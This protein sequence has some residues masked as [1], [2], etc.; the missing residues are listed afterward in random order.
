MKAIEKIEALTFKRVHSAVE[1]LRPGIALETVYR[2]RA[3]LRAG[4]GVPDPV[5]AVLIE[6]TR[7]TE[8]PIVF[9]DFAPPDM[10]ARA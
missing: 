6:A 10:G 1:G 9:A 5:K 8:H 2:W 4:R 3:A 7:D